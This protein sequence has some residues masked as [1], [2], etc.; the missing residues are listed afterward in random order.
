MAQEGG[1]TG[2]D[3]WADKN[4]SRQAPASNVN[5]NA[6][7]VHSFRYQS[8]STKP[9]ANPQQNYSTGGGEG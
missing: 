2:Q 8:E 1:P 3:Y 4:A 6:G 7:R 9:G 5:Q